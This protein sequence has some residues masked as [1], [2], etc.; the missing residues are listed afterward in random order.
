MV[1]V[2]IKNSFVI[3][4]YKFVVCKFEKNKGENV[5]YLLKNKK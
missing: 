4:K 5:F 2:S 3:V 1:N